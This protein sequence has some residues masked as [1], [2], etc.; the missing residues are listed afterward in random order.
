VNCAHDGAK[1]IPLFYS[2]SWSTGRFP[3][4]VLGNFLLQATGRHKKK[5][6]IDFRVSES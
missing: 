5:S 1:V 3:K 6:G 4:V 2:F